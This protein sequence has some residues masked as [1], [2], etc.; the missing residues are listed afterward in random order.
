MDVFVW[1][2]LPLVC[3]ITPTKTHGKNTQPDGPAGHAIFVDDKPGQA[4][5]A[6]QDFVIF[7]LCRCI[8]CAREEGRVS[9]AENHLKLQE[10]CLNYLAA[11]IRKGMAGMG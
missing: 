10:R 7:I 9:A 6:R 11:I 1:S 3:P 5:S 4:P 2:G 8:C